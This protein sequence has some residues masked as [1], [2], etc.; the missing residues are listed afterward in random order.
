MR[1]GVKPYPELSWSISR[2]R[3]LDRCPRA[4]YC[5]YY[6]AWNGWLDEGRPRYGDPAAAG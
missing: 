3:K 4:F 2:P 6:L 1:F 5:S